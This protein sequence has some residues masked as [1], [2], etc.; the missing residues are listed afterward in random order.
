MPDLT[1]RVACVT[2]ANSGIG[3][4]TARVSYFVWFRLKVSGV[5]IGEANGFD[6]SDRC[7]WLTERGCTWLVPRIPELNLSWEYRG[8][9][10]GYSSAERVLDVV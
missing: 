3:K 4:E 10:N 1:G 2:G 6:S 9:G 7:C 8:P 5:Q